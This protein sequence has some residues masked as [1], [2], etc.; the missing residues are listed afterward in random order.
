MAPRR[1][2]SRRRRCRSAAGEVERGEGA[3]IR[4]SVTR[5]A[6]ASTAVPAVDQY[7]PSPPLNSSKSGRYLRRPAGATVLSRVSPSRSPVMAISNLPPVN[8]NVQ[9]RHAEC[10]ETQ[11]FSPSR[12]EPSSSESVHLGA[13]NMSTKY[14]CGQRSASAAARSCREPPIFLPHLSWPNLNRSA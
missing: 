4:L 3:P 9:Q 11:L 8:P 10:E 6:P 7:R 13:S 12:R 2:R 14:R 5:E 1:R